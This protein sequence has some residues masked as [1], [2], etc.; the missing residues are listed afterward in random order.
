M[1]RGTSRRRADTREGDTRDAATRGAP[2]AS[3]RSG[4]V[5]DSPGSSSFSL[6]SAS[7]VSRLLDQAGVSDIEDDLVFHLWLEQEAVLERALPMQDMLASE[8][9][10]ER[11]LIA[12]MTA[13][14][15]RDLDQFLLMLQQPLLLL[16]Q[17]G[18][19]RSAGF[20]SGTPRSG[21]WA[22][23]W[24]FDGAVR[25]AGG[26]GRAG[27]AERNVPLSEAEISRSTRRWTFK[28]AATDKRKGERTVQRSSDR[29]ALSPVNEDTSGPPRRH[30]SARSWSGDVSRSSTRSA[31]SK[32]GPKL[33][34]MQPGIAAQPPVPP[35]AIGSR[36]AFSGGTGG[37]YS[38]ETSAPPPTVSGAAPSGNGGGRTAAGKMTE[39]AKGEARVDTGDS[40]RCCCI[41]L[42]EYQ[43]GDDMMTLRCMHLFHYD[44]VHDW[45][46]HSGRRTCPLCLVAI[47]EGEGKGEE[48]FI[49]TEPTLGDTQGEGD[50]D[51]TGLP[52]M[53]EAVEGGEPYEHPREE[54][55]I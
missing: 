19:W 13:V 14:G 16:H 50:G 29:H 31:L 22:R 42:A 39:N 7:S 48:D 46:V 37:G 12:S 20:A 8:E 41:C 52:H 44:C 54:Q 2:S 5:G 3:S 38:K 27:E 1:N 45:L 35:G 40:N 30:N 51:C 10:L 25:V 11:A 28:R 18:R 43:T 32:Q 49:A 36:E 4:G 23:L 53:P 21:G 17:S 15:R 9:A 55:E 24:G 33:P 26:S 6:P 34:P 47:K